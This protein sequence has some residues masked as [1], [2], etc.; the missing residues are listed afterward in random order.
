MKKLLFM[1]AFVCSTFAIQAQDF[2]FGVGYGNAQEFFGDDIKYGVTA[3]FGVDFDIFKKSNFN[4]GPAIGIV[5]TG[6]LESDIETI[7]NESSLLTGL[8]AGVDLG[9]FTIKGRQSVV[10]PYTDK[11]NDV[12]FTSVSG[13]Q[14]EYKLKK[15]G[16]VALMLGGDYFFNRELFH[17]TY[18][19]KTG[20]TLKF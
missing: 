3:N 6:D 4:L 14:V 7:E 12:F 2:S 17:Y 13:G 5:W 11:N 1:L 9:R 16:F 15:D 18:Q 8:H 10:L 19:F 20:I